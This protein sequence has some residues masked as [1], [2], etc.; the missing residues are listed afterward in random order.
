M[1]SRV[2]STSTIST[3]SLY[4]APNEFN[5]KCFENLS[6]KLPQYNQSFH[7]TMPS[8]FKK[9]SPTSNKSLDQRNCKITFEKPSITLLGDQDNMMFAS[10]I[11]DIHLKSSG[12]LA[13]TILKSKHSNIE[14]YPMEALD[15]LDIESQ[16]YNTSLYL[17]TALSEINTIS[18]ILIRNNKE[19]FDFPR[20][21]FNIKRKPSKT[22]EKEPNPTESAVLSTKPSLHNFDDFVTKSSEVISLNEVDKVLDYFDMR[23]QGDDNNSE[24]PISNETITSLF[25]EQNNYYGNETDEEQQLY[26][27]LNNS[28]EK[29][30]EMP[31]LKRGEL[32]TPILEERSEFLTTITEE[33]S[34]LDINQL[35]S[36]KFLM[37]GS[38]SLE[39]E[40]II[41]KNSM[42][43]EPNNLYFSFA[44]LLNGNS[45]ENANFRKK[46]T[47]NTC[48]QESKNSN[49][50][51]IPLPRPKSITK[52]IEK[53]ESTPKVSET[54][55]NSNGNARNSNGNLRNSNDRM[56]SF[57]ESDQKGSFRNSLAE[58][59][60]KIDSFSQYF[61]EDQENSSF[62]SFYESI[63]KK[64][65]ETGVQNA[66][67]TVKKPT[68]IE[69]RENAAP[70]V[71]ASYI[72]KIISSTNGKK[73][74]SNNK[75]NVNKGKKELNFKRNKAK[76]E[77]IR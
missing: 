46:D 32:L 63:V 23:L 35:P 73:T 53:Q 22:N 39:I 30:F 52:G 4:K 21:N 18:S 5:E 72:R 66:V 50:L 37:N 44:E 67:L 38:D 48:Y 14:K 25:I 59:S 36:P 6:S 13:Q 19:S 20:R 12:I 16:P 17:D 9:K 8:L 64:K 68:L 29:S 11:S 65:H 74:N 2:L 56:K 60:D 33:R 57:H 1:D 41:S 70:K 58:R 34:E 15:F 7:Q 43:E 54:L 24:R 76:D 45:S 61:K 55:R 40:N 26:E 47:K 27:I 71:E 62:E 49:K 28:N 77:D 42:I 51:T 3:D 10:S 31:I 69:R 75:E